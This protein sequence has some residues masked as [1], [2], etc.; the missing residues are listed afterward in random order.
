MSM[1]DQDL[2]RNA[3]NHVPLSPISFLTRAARI[4][5]E[6]TAVIHGE[7]RYSYAQFLERVRR[8]A[9]ALAECLHPVG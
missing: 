3:A 5:P 1:F 7:T 8:L 4:Y 9:S 6:R 2:D